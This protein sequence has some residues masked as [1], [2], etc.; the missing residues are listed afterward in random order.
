[1]SNVTPNERD[2]DGYVV[3]NPEL[4]EQLRLEQGVSRRAFAD[5]AETSPTTA[6]RFF[7][8][9]RVQTRIAK[10]LFDGLGIL[11]MTPYL[12]HA[13][14]EAE[15]DAVDA[16][17]LSEWQ[18]ENALTHP[19]RLSNGLEFRLFQLSHKVLPHT[20]GRGKCYDLRKLNT[21]AA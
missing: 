6:Y 12:M 20:F 17:V 4:L 21:R 10:R 3:L 8:R 1:L 9:Q 5:I 18:I 16:Q 14:G 7:D 11:D 2:R 13:D 15:L 19:V